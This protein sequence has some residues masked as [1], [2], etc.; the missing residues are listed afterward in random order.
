MTVEI[1]MKDELDAFSVDVTMQK[2]IDELNL[3]GAQGKQFVIVGTE[4]LEPRMIAVPNISWA[5]EVADS[6]SMFS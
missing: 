1:K 5:R 3:A 4:T 2:L 6:D